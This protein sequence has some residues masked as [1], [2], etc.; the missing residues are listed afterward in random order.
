MTD[1]GKEKQNPMNDS[2]SHKRRRARQG[3]HA[4]LELSLVAP[5]LLFLFSGVFDMGF[6]E[7]CLI[8]AENAARVA[9][10]HTSSA[11]AFA[12]DSDGACQYALAEM[13]MLSNVNTLTSCGASPLVV[14]ATAVTGVDGNP[15]TNVS[16]AYT[17]N[18]LIPIP[19]LTGKTTVTRIAQM[20]VKQ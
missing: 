18:Q 7:Y 10:L 17:T 3:G 15:A 9:A 4:I 12:S 2:S 5:W 11:S 13:K 16:V 19:G 20:R 8:S 6:Y 1:P 14:T